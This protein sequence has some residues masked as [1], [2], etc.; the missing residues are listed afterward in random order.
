MT[1]AELEVQAGRAANCGREK[2]ADD[3]GRAA[4][5]IRQLE[6]ERER[7]LGRVAVLTDERD[8]A[9]HEAAEVRRLCET[10]AALGAL[11][12][13]IREHPMN[14]S[15]PYP[16]RPFGGE[17]VFSIDAAGLTAFLRHLDSLLP[18][19]PEVVTGA[20]GNRYSM[21]GGQLWIDWVRD[22]F[23]T[24]GAKSIP[25]EDAPVVAALM[26]KGGKDD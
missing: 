7:L 10:D 17:S 13:R 24:M 26:A 19:E 5:R 25:V 15:L 4:A 8:R 20:S 3:F 11:V 21:V 14:R 12:R 23:R 16:I 9:K 22:G 6:G 18:K 2:W 1:A